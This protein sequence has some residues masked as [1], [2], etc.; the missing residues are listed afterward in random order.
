V[1]CFVF[2]F[3]CFVLFF[4][5]FVVVV[6]VAVVVVV[7]VCLFFTKSHCYVSGVKGTACTSNNTIEVERVLGIEAARLVNVWDPCGSSE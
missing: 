7:F 4:V 6:V 2:V 3:L 1:F 5:F